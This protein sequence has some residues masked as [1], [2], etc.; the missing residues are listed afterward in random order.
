MFFFTKFYCLQIPVFTGSSQQL[1]HQYSGTEQFLWSGH[2]G[3]NDFGNLVPTPPLT[4]LRDEPA[5]VA[6]LREAKS[7][8]M[9]GI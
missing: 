2:D 7:K 4:L 1:L 6:M 9:E 5:A 3:F 8:N